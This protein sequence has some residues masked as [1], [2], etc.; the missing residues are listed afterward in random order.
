MRAIR[1]G[2]E[3]ASKGGS[4]VSTSK[5]RGGALA[6]LAA[7][8]LAGFLAGCDNGD[9]E[10]APTEELNEG[11]ELSQED[12]APVDGDEQIAGEEE[13]LEED[14]CLA[15]NTLCVTLQIP[16]TVQ[17]TPELL[18]VGLYKSLPPMGPPDVF[19]PFSLEAPELVAGEDLELVLDVNA[20]GDH[21]IYAVLY[22]PG[23]GAASWQPMSG[24]DHVGTSAAIP[25]DGSGLI[26]DEPIAFELAP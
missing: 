13:T 16:E 5:A 23:G 7:L 3:Q 11:S 19:P 20:T 4:A 8:L 22:M 24:V 21:Q 10:S 6:L 14:P 12:G 9:G 15:D 17:E 1:R 26:L 25:L 2:S 18:I